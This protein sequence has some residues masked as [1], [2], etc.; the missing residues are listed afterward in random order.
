M[1]TVAIA[2]LGT[3]RGALFLSTEKEK[4]AAPAKMSHGLSQN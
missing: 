4:Q 2:R 1:N 3:H